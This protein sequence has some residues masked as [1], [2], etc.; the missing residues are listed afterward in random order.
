MPDDMFARFAAQPDPRDEDGSGSRKLGGQFQLREGEVL[1]A[2]DRIPALPV[3]VGRILALVGDDHSNAQR[4]E[5]LITQDMVIAGRVLKLVNSSFY[6]RSQAVGSI[7]AAVTIIGFSSLRSL[8]LAASTS[9]LMLVDLKPYGMNEGGLWRNSMATGAVAR[10]VGLKAGAGPDAAEE[11]FAAGL[12]RDVGM[13]VLAP[14]LNKAGMKLKHGDRD[15]IAQ[16]RRAI[17]FDHAWVG[18]L[19]AEKW[20]LPATLRASI[21]QHHRPPAAGDPA[22]LR[23][24]AAV[25]L[26]ERL[27]YAAGV[28][29]QPDHPFDVQIDSHLVSRAGLDATSFAAVCADVPALIKS[30]ES[31]G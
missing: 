27:V 11:W 19:L 29:V 18:D 24:T 31:S 12:L 13:L 2:I 5:S 3:V 26:A 16:E 23:Q 1:A 9:N 17:G 15:V 20:S 22:L 21:G 30:V 14:F 28:G 8:V 4:I 25:R 10:A 7:A 6:R